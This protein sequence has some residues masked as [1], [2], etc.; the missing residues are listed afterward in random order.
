MDISLG[1]LN[2]AVNQLKAARNVRLALNA[3]FEDAT[4]AAFIGEQLNE[5]GERT[6]TMFC[7]VGNTFGNLDVGERNF[8]SVMRGLMRDDDLLLFDTS[9][10]G[11]SWSVDGDNRMRPHEE[12]RPFKEF[13]ASALSWLTSQ[14]ADTILNDYQQRI[15]AEVQP[16]LSDVPDTPTIVISDRDTNRHLLRFRRFR[17]R[18]TD[19]MAQIVGKSQS[20]ESQY[21]AAGT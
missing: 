17:D 12:G 4:G 21:Y 6:P 3:D 2:H 1:L 14:N 10:Q 18:P 19:R 5:L 20:C 11:E 9:V 13:I 8:I 7:L 16:H 15:A